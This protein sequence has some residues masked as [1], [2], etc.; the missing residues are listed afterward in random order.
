MNQFD[1][2]NSSDDMNALDGNLVQLIAQDEVRADDVDSEAFV[3]AVHNRVARR[4]FAAKT[5]AASGAAAVAICAGAIGLLAPEAALYPVKLVQ[6]VITS[7]T[8]AVAC[9][10]G[11]IA[12]CWWT[13]Y[14]EA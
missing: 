4:R 14:G 9:V 3:A 11:A 6:D 2:M 8:G 10:L 13:R 1:G 12:L 5:L 7:P